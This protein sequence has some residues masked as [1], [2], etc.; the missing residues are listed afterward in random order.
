MNPDGYVEPLMLSIRPGLELC[1]KTTPTYA[2][3]YTP[4]VFSHRRAGTH[5][6]GEFINTHWSRDWLKSHDFPERLP[7]DKYP[8]F[9]VVRNPI[10]VIHATFNWWNSWGGAHN[11]EVAD[12]IAGISFA[13]YLEGA[14]GK[15]IGYQSWAV[16]D[17]DNFHVTR[18]ME[19]DPIRYWRDHYRAALEAGVKIISYEELS[20]RP[21][22]AAE[23]V[24]QVIGDLEDY[25][26]I[27][28]MPPVGM[29]PNIKKVGHAFKNWPSWAISKVESLTPAKMVEQAGFSSFENWIFG[30]VE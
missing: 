11:P 25:S 5:L 29:S 26:A 30:K 12:A 2:E 6:L 9:Y 27:Q 10:D 3:K 15:I 4:I 22:R 8:T 1:Y 13:E 17:K 24:A 28:T 21:R 23:K 7:I 19:Y 16:G 14:F 20:L 18:G